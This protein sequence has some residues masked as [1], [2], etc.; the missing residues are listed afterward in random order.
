MTRER[1]KA[2]RDLQ[3]EKEQFENNLEGWVF[4]N[5]TGYICP[6]CEVAFKE[7][8]EQNFMYCD[9]KQ[10]ENIEGFNDSKEESE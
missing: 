5:S 3:A 7:Y 2:Y 6:E 4:H 10:Y 8:V 1:L 9:F